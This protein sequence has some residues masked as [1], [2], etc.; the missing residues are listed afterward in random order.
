MRRLHVAA[1]A[2]AFILAGSEPTA[3]DPCS[4][5]PAARLS[6]D[7]LRE[8]NRTAWQ[9]SWFPPPVEFEAAGEAEALEAK[10]RAA[11]PHND[12]GAI[13]LCPKRYKLTRDGCQ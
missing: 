4:D 7:A 3:A 12:P 13:D 8:C 2:A 10:R 6:A 5:I 1:L 9:R 11:L